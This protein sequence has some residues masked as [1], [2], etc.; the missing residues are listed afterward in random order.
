MTEEFFRSPIPEELVMEYF[1]VLVE[2]MPLYIVVMVSDSNKQPKLLLEGEGEAEYPRCKIFFKKQDVSKYLNTMSELKRIKSDRLQIWETSRTRF[3]RF[4]LAF[5]RS[6][7]KSGRKGI[8]VRGTGVHDGE[9]RELDTFW[10]SD[11][12]RIC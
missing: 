8:T 9:F 4:I 10:T 7:V 11:P 2:D 6:L 3:S 1:L 5:N 12:S